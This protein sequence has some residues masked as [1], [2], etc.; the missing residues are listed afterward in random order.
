MTERRASW[1]HSVSKDP[2]MPLQKVM[3]NPMENPNDNTQTPRRGWLKNGNPRG[4]PNTAPRCGARTRRGTHVRHPPCVTAD[5]GCT[6]APVRALVPRMVWRDRGARVGNTGCI[7]QRQ[8]GTKTR[9]LPSTTESGATEAIVTTH[10]V[11]LAITPPSPLAP[12]L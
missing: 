10:P 11:V 1:V 5:V 7:L 8:G 2:W 9:T 12:P 4:D 6:G 3:E